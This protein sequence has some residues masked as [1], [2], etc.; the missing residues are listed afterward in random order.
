MGGS[1]LRHVTH[2]IAAKGLPADAQIGHLVRRF[3][4]LLLLVLKRGL[5]ESQGAGVLQAC[6]LESVSQKPCDSRC[7]NLCRLSQASLGGID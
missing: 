6:S 4:R 3:P 1:P 5:L 2:A 7:S